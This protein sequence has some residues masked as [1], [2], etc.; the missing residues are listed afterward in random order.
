MLYFFSSLSP[1]LGLGGNIQQFLILRASFLCEIFIK[2]PNISSHRLHSQETH[3][4]P[5]LAIGLQKVIHAKRDQEGGNQIS[6]FPIFNPKSLS[7]LLLTASNIMR[8]RINCPTCWQQHCNNKSNFLG[9]R[10][11]SKAITIQRILLM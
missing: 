9:F 1:F 2:S 5:P 8:E 10:I 11:L 4:W 3:Q 7:H 6:L